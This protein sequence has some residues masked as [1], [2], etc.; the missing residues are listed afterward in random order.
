MGRLGSLHLRNMAAVEHDVLGVRQRTA[1]VFREA[2]RHERIVTA[3]DEQAR[4]PQ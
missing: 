3:P 4:R 2:E 1:H